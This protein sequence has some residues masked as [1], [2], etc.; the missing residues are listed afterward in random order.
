M[1]ML[2][3][4]ATAALKSE[5]VQK[6]SSVFLTQV[7]RLLISFAA[8]VMITRMLGPTN[9]G[10][11]ALA[12]AVSA[13]GV[14]FA[15]L[16]LHTANTYFAARRPE[17]LSLLLGNTV[18]VSF[19]FGAFVSVTLWFVAQ[20]YGVIGLRG[21]ILIQA[22]VCIPLG[23][24][25]LLGQNLLIGVHKLSAYNRAEILSKAVPLVLVGVLL[26]ARVRTVETLFATTIAGL[27]VGCV[28]TY[29]R[30][31]KNATC[32]PKVSLPFMRENI[33]YAT[34]AY[35]AALFCFLV[36]RSDLFL[37]QMKLGAEQ[38]GY[39]SVAVTLA[40]TLSLLPASVA[41]VVFP[42]F[43][44]SSDLSEKLRLLQK[45]SLGTAGILL[46]ILSSI[47]VLSRVVI[48]TLFGPAFASSSLAFVLL[49]PGIFFLGMHSV[50]VQMLN[51]MGYPKS[52]VYIWACCAFLNISAN[53]FVIPV[54]GIAGASITSS[55]SYFLA[56]ILVAGVILRIRPPRVAMH[57]VQESSTA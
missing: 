5:L 38:A 3:H 1:R 48:V 33:G 21:E 46:V 19:G 28:F 53:L 40:E 49:L 26:L 2:W 9:R 4:R 50:I 23:L 41:T 16:G 7:V 18:L 11:F 54:Y 27:A 44:A 56:C 25:Y 20:F 52:V 17:S 12:T 32:K 55:I 57:F 34:R 37:V 29:A 42:R 22:L 13:L 36:I 47:A 39:Y 45:V 10:I 8:S 15:N 35:L 43:S 14:Q 51:G 6:I 24:A 30:L 31:L